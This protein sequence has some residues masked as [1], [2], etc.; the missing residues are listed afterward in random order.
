MAVRPITQQFYVQPILNDI[1]ND[2]ELRELGSPD[3][4]GF[5][6]CLKA[7][8]LGANKLMTRG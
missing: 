2:E 3:R 5:L 6:A 7:D 1:F 8:A 4:M